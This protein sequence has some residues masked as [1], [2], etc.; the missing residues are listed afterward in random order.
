MG[1]YQCQN[2]VCRSKINTDNDEIS[3]GS[4]MFKC[5]ECG[6]RQRIDLPPGEAT[7]S[8]ARKNTT[9][10]L[11][12][13][14]NG[15]RTYEIAAAVDPDIPS[16]ADDLFKLHRC[17]CEMEY[18]PE[19]FKTTQRVLEPDENGDLVAKIK[20]VEGTRIPVGP[21][22]HS[23][24]FLIIHGIEAGPDRTFHPPLKSAT[25]TR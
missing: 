20:V 16:Y 10:V 13:C 1:L 23:N 3:A 14:P 21:G 24:E 17:T 19:K 8:I 6:S 15:G 7:A 4:G 11:R 5:K 9:V 12:A 22:S 18:A 2:E 25:I